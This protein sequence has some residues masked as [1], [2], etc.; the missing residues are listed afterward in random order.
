MI[1]DAGDLVACGQG[2]PPEWCDSASAA[3]AWALTQ[4]VKVSA[5]FVPRVLTDCLGLVHAVEKGEAAVYAANMRLARTWKHVA[6]TL[7]G[8][9]QALQNSGSIT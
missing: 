5:P 2:I 6:N 8:N 9:L 4:A 3:E 7:D 1:S